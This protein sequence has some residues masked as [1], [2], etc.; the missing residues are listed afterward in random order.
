MKVTY[1]L[2]NTILLTTRVGVPLP[3]DDEPNNIFK[4]K[5]SQKEYISLQ[6]M[7]T[8]FNFIAFSLKYITINWLLGPPQ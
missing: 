7:N 5:P 6:Y 4:F 2:A 8:G 3:Q 1:G